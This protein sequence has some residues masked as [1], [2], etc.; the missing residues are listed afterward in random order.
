MTSNTAAGGMIFR[1]VKAVEDLAP[2]GGEKFTPDEGAYQGTIEATKVRPLTYLGNKTEEELNN[3]G[4]TSPDVE[5]LSFQIGSVSALEGQTDF[6]N[7]KFFT[8]DIIV[9]DGELTIADEVPESAWQ[10]A[11]SQTAL[12]AVAVALGVA[13]EVTN[14]AGESGYAIANSTIESLL[15]GEFDGQRLGFVV[16]HRKFTRK[17]GE[18]GVEVQVSQYVPAV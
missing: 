2:K 13:E 5:A 8:P 14:E 17:N 15:G 10:I 4:F 18:A 7:R 12:L 1:P 3:Q 9:R 11:R 16:K 6:G